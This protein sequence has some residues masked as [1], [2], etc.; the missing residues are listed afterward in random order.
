M[1]AILNYRSSTVSLSSTH[2]NS[3]EKPVFLYTRHL[4]RTLHDKVHLPLLYL[5]TVLRASKNIQSSTI[6]A[7]FLPLNAMQLTSLVLLI[8]KCERQ[9]NATIYR[10][11][12]V[13]ATKH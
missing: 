3:A 1:K 8:I 6:H 4:A 9:Q 13:A 2:L 12:M 7:S 5:V 11:N 10:L